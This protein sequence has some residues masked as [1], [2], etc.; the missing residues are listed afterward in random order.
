MSKYATGDERSEA[1]KQRDRNNRGVRGF[2]KSTIHGTTDPHKFYQL[3][4]RTI[5]NY[6]K[7]DP[8]LRA[9]AREGAQKSAKISNRKAAT[10]TPD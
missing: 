4:L 3:A 6:M 5:R 9:R 7:I 2:H 1:I 10:L 8:K